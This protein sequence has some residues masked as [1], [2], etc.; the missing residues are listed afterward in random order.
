V[1]P[2]RAI[3]SFDVNS[4]CIFGWFCFNQTVIKMFETF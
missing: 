2:V 1:M 4:S 3:T